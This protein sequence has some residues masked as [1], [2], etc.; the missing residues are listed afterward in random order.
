MVNPDLHQQG[1]GTEML[2][3]MLDYAFRQLGLRRIHAQIM[4]PNISSQKLFEKLGFQKEGIL[5]AHVLRNNEYLDMLMYGLLRD[6]WPVL[7]Y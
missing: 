3:L 1:F 6:E 2:T 4:A 7:E 5:R